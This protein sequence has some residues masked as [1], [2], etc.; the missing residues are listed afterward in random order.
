M[1]LDSLLQALVLLSVSLPLFVMVQFV[2]TAPRL[3]SAEDSSTTLEDDI[4]K[5][6]S[7]PYPD[8][9]PGTQN[10]IEYPNSTVRQESD[11]QRNW[12]PKDEERHGRTL[13]L[14]FD[15]TGDQFDESN[16]NIVELVAMLRK[17]DR[18]KQL[19]YYQPGI[20]THGTPFSSSRFLAGVYKTLDQMLAFTLES[21]IR[22][23]YLF[24]MENHTVGDKVCLFGFSR[25]AYTARA[26]AGMIQKV[27]LLSRGNAEQLPFAF[28]MYLREDHTG[29]HLSKMFKEAFSK[30]VK[31]DFL[32]VWDTV[33]SV[34][35]RTPRL[36]FVRTNNGIRC[37]RHALSLDEHRTKFMP[38]FYKKAPSKTEPQ[39]PATQGNGLPPQISNLSTVRK[40]IL[41]PE[42]YDPLSEATKDEQLQNE[43]ETTRTDCQEVFF[44]GSHCDVGGGSVK[45]GTRHSLARI[46]LRWMV[47]EC[48]RAKTGL[49]FDADLLLRRAG[50]DMASNLPP[51][52]SPGP[53]DSLQVI[54]KQPSPCPSNCSAAITSPVKSEWTKLPEE[55]EE[56]N[57]ALSPIYDQ[58]ELRRVWWI[59]EMTP[60]RHLVQKPIKYANDPPKMKTKGFANKGQGRII[61]R[62]VIN[63]NGGGELHIHRSVKTRLEALDGN[64]QKE[65]YV[66]RIQP[67]FEG[68]G[69]PSSL[70]HQEWMKEKRIVWVDE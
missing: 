50:L 15:G 25:G 61:L 23:E 34:G 11:A 31:I 8:P 57:D 9:R 51:R 33:A 65:T 37:F 28:D 2:D 62:H 3:H 53:S 60:I 69:G 5:S 55:V 46:P 12:I 56:L 30:D 21:H 17:D 35:L 32:G 58:L 48:F 1:V 26:L 70:R 42:D 39:P 44:A 27:G 41:R 4:R 36:P 13:V 54:S 43:K 29:L 38:F 40:E 45:N 22:A 49:I 59:L 64:G 14:C 67:D 7:V 20:G 19:V 52:L 16:S 10:G 24:L 6:N 63:S 47:R 18:H 66:P 68:S